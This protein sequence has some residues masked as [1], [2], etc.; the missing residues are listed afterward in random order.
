M[1]SGTEFDLCQPKQ[2]LAANLRLKH[3]QPRPK[4][5]LETFQPVNIKPVH[6]IPSKM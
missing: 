2:N 5:Y 6:S 3:I 4:S 1:Q